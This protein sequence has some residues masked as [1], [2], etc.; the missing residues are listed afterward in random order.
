MTAS[1]KPTTTGTDSSATL[2][3]SKKA[4]F[5]TPDRESA[6][7]DLPE[8]SLAVAGEC[9][10]VTPPTPNGKQV[11]FDKENADVSMKRGLV[12]RRGGRYGSPSRMTP[13][14]TSTTATEYKTYRS[15]K[16]EETSLSD[17]GVP[18]L[19]SSN[20]DNLREAPSMISCSEGETTS[21]LTE[22]SPSKIPKA[23]SRN[24]TFSPRPNEGSQLEKTS[25]KTPTRSPLR[26]HFHNLPSLRDAKLSSP[27][28][29]FLSPC[30]TSPSA[31]AT[32]AG[33][34]RDEY[35]EEKSTKT[36]S[37][38]RERAV[39]TPTDFA[40]DFG[41]GHQSSASF[42][43]SNVLAWLQ[44]PSSNGLF[45]PGGLGS[46]LNTPRAPRTPRTPTHTSFF[47]SDVASFPRNG[48]FASPKNKRPGMISI[49]PLAPKR[50][51]VQ[52]RSMPLLG[53]S[54]KMDVMNMADRDLLEDED[55]SV[56]L[57]LASHSNTPRSKDG[58][59]VFRSPRGRKGGYDRDSSNPALQLP[60][61]G[62]SDGPG[63]TSKLSH[64]ACIKGCLF[65]GQC[66]RE[67]RQAAFERRSLVRFA[68]SKEE[69]LEEQENR[70]GAPQAGYAM[71]PYPARS[72]DGSYYMPSGMPAMP[73]G[74]SMRI[75]IGGPPPMNSRSGSKSSSNSSSSPLR[76]TGGP[77]GSPGRHPH[78]HMPPDGYGAPPGSMYPP[79]HYH[80]PPPHMGLP[81]GHYPH[82]PPRHIPPM[83]PNSQPPS[84]SSTS[85]GNSKKVKGSKTSKAP[86]A[87]SK[88]PAPVVADPVVSEKP[89][90]SKKIRKAPP[91]ESGS[92]KKKKAAVTPAAAAPADPVDR[93]KA[94][95]TIA[96]VN[97]ASGGMNDR[98]AALAA[99]ILRGVTMR[100]SGK[101]QA[102]L[103]YAGKSRYIGVFDT[104][105]KAALAYEIAREKLKSDNKTPADQSAQT[106]KATENA[107]NAARKA[108]FD[109]VN[110]KDPR[111]AGK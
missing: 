46:A 34:L 28:G 95:A 88:R 11:R 97:A 80:H 4:A 18:S 75:H 67:P 44:S 25:K 54:P 93:H 15:P 24:V 60:L 1:P 101:W 71:P 81:Y 16:R 106:F 56:L 66:E 104:R 23:D 105:E 111:V 42:D 77:A 26:N 85:K 68:T 32:I 10:T 17:G 65:T 91:K 102:Q 49:S 22:E 12:S 35:E 107:V 3:G 100:P 63:S 47:F 98:A 29:I 48:E 86:A 55:L 45:S 84:K 41:K 89:S 9:P 13:P 58:G 59:D 5:E 39:A 92:A 70:K 19:C 62:R 110:E 96:A 99:A 6:E 52:P 38:E 103:Y 72:A 87:G 31:Y 73:P 64:K 14:T 8:E 51:F 94:A 21:P 53:E 82:P 61:I 30:P 40:V 27:C 20:C 76:H 33:P 36:K 74:G 50:K 79:P 43:A 69:E 7:L 83:Y 37:E 57:Q 2:K 108:A 90:P 109:G 78:Y